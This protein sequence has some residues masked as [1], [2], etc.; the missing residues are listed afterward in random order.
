MI[1]R[2]RCRCVHRAIVTSL[3]TALASLRSS[4]TFIGL[5]DATDMRVH[6]LTAILNGRPSRLTALAAVVLAAVDRM[7]DLS[8]ALAT[9]RRQ[10]YVC[11]NRP[12]ASS[13]WTLGL[14]QIR[15]IKSKKSWRMGTYIH[16]DAGVEVTGMM[17]WGIWDQHMPKIFPA[18]AV[19]VTTLS[20][21]ALSSKNK[22]NLAHA[23]RGWSTN[24]GR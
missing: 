5:F 17:E 10:R 7:P 16:S 12:P 13:L 4:H 1:F 6:A 2:T 15:Y 8:L 11:Q 19:L 18:K 21:S 20:L 14:L 23:R 3:S 9:T 22:I 24:N